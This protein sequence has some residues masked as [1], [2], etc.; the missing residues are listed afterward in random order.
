MF[1]DTDAIRA[2][3]S[4]NSAHA[5]DLADVAATLSSLP[6]A[7]S[8]RSLG[9]VGAGFLSALTAALADGSRAAAALSERLWASNAAAYAVASAYDSTDSAAGIRIAG[10]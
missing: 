4:A 8:G 7:A 1:A 2:L 5:D 10:A 3:G 9:A 6:I